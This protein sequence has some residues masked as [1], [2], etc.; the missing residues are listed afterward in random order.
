MIFKHIKIS[1]F[2]GIK[3]SVLEDLNQ[4][5]IFVGK[6]NS[7]KTSMLE[8]IFLLTGI[9]NAELS[10]RID[11]YRNLIHNDENDFRFIF[12]N[13]NY[14]NI[15][16]FESEL[17]LPDHT[18]KLTITPSSTF[19]NN[20]KAI[21]LSLSRLNLT[22]DSA[23]SALLD[24]INL[25]TFEGEL[26]KKH[27]QKKNI[28]SSISIERIQNTINFKI[29]PQKD[30]KEDF[31]GIY[32]NDKN[33]P[34][35]TYRRIEQLIIQKKK[36]YIIDNLKLIDPAI[37]DI[38]TGSNN[39]LYYDIGAERLLPS[40]MLGDGII[41]IVSII[42]AMNELKNG[43]L[44]IDEIDNGLHYSALNILWKIVFQ[45]SVENNNQ[46]FISTHN[47]E[48]LKNLSEFVNQHEEYKNIINC[49]TLSKIPGNEIK[50]YKYNFE[51][52]KNAMDNNIEIRGKY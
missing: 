26:K 8:S 48:A 24:G 18:R 21:E 34:V 16:V 10:L 27:T 6:N 36:N 52:L 14:K 46:L 12:Y 37:I 3:K 38:T 1:N 20:D 11:N 22:S 32:L 39:M 4:V 43:I 23:S 13:L 7:C 15:P 9:S 40:N 50:S 49:Y 19:I 29:T 31:M 35:E 5:N 28:K 51:E 42:A 17:H 2:R 44:L 45:M 41:K 33:S 47:N 30:Y 25:L